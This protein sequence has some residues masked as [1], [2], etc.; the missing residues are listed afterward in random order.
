VRAHQAV[1]HVFFFLILGHRELLM[2]GQCFFFVL[3][4]VV[5]PV[6]WRGAYINSFCW[7]LVLFLRRLMVAANILM[8]VAVDRPGGFNL[9]VVGGGV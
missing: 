6:F 4:D 8:R 1:C 3:F 5:G 9:A 7:C 2:K